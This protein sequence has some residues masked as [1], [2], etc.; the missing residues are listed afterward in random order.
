MQ[1]GQTKHV[2]YGPAASDRQL[3]WAKD[4]HMKWVLEMLVAGREIETQGMASRHDGS[5]FGGFL[6]VVDPA[7]DSF[8][9]LSRCSNPLGQIVA[10]SSV[11]LW[12]FYKSTSLLIP[13]LMANLKS[14]LIQRHAARESNAHWP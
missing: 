14:L 3:T 10:F 7:S 1:E 9:A 12:R 6:E 11:E 2:I 13:D 8:R 4:K 5:L